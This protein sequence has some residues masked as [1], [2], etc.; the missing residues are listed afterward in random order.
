MV[1]EYFPG[2]TLERHCNFERLLPIHRTI[3]IIFKCCMAL[4][5]AYR[6]GDHCTA[7]SSRPTS[8]SMTRTT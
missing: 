3:G 8:S 4:D 7:T 2:D 5:Y 1:M 6:Q